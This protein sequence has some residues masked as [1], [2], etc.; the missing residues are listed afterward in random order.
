MN[1]T[2]AT[3]RKSRLYVFTHSGLPDIGS[4]PRFRAED[5]FFPIHPLHM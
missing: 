5:L 4:S 1:D 3:E 2:V